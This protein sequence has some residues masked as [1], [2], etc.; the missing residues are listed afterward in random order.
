MMKI[1]GGVLVGA[2]VGAFAVEVIRR[3]RPEILASVGQKAR[4]SADAVVSA[5]RNG[6]DRPGAE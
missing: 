5:F 1:L 3:L 6:Y 4:S 2:F